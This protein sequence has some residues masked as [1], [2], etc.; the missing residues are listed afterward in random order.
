LTSP[1]TKKPAIAGFFVFL[2]YF[3]ILLETIIW[4]PRQGFRNRTTSQNPR[5]YWVSDCL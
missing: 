4:S 1:K 3:L 5:R 2:C